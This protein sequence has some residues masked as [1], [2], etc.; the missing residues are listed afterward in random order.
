LL[1]NVPSI[2]IPDQETARLLSRDFRRTLQEV[3]ER[4]KMNLG[5]TSILSEWLWNR[6]HPIKAF[7][8]A[9]LDAVGLEKLTTTLNAMGITVDEWLE[10]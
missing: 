10:Q 8:K 4:E 6:Q 3:Y 7:D 5:E 9:V 1:Y 2:P